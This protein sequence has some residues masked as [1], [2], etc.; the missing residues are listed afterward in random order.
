MKSDTRKNV[1]R[2]LAIR[3]TEGAI[4][5]YAKCC[6]PI[7]G[8]PILGFISKGRG[9]VIHTRDCKNTKDYRAR[10]DKWV[11]VHWESTVDSVY[12]VDVRVDTVNRRGV[13]AT[14]ASTIADLSSNIENVT[15]SE[16][17]GSH[18]TLSFTIS[19]RD[20]KH[21][22]NIIRRVRSLES[23]VKISRAK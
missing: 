16:R 19:V 8:D 1:S 5:S 23:V 6:K 15:I 22:A 18:S 11:D 17:D 7:P 2:P 3:G 10:P 4:V 13:L 12:P 20:R 9:I 14:V 21:L